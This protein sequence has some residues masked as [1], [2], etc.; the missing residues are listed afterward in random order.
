MTHESEPATVETKEE[1]SDQDVG[2]QADDLRE[3]LQRNVDAYPPHDSEDSFE[4]EHVAD[5]L[6]R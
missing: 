3:E 5:E 4:L 6:R 2:D 1:L